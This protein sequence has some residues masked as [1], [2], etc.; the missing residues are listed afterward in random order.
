MTPGEGAAGADTLGNVSKDDLAR[1]SS[2]V[3]FLRADGQHAHAAAE[4]NEALGSKR[5]L[6]CPLHSGRA[7][8][9][10]RKILGRCTDVQEQRVGLRLRPRLRL[11]PGNRPRLRGTPSWTRHRPRSS[12]REASAPWRWPR[13]HERLRVVARLP[14]HRL[15]S[16]LSC[17]RAASPFQPPLPTQSL[18]GAAPLA[19]LRGRQARGPA[20]AQIPGRRS[21]RVPP[22]L[23]HFP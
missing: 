14:R 18:D 20:G 16:R 4:N 8:A 2:H 9:A 23:G 3:L 21:E 12:L 1:H 13:H 11:D 10:E 5:P 22:P 15:I 17:R 7:D 6:K 19:A